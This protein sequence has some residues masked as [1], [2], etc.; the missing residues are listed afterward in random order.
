[1]IS[2]VK[3]YNSHRHKPLIGTEPLYHAEP[4]PTETAH[5]H[6]LMVRMVL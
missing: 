1:M 2:P 4:N 3:L 6:G 5:Y